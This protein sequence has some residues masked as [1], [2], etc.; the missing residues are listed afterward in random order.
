MT[1]RLADIYRREGEGGHIARIALERPPGNLIDREVAA[2]LRQ[3]P[4]E[5]D[6]EPAEVR[7]VLL[8]GLPTGP[9][10]AGTD[11][12]LLEE[13][14]RLSATALAD[15][16]DGY[17]VASS[18]AAIQR[19]VVAAIEGAAYEQGLELALAADVRVAGEGATFRLDHVGQG[20]IPWD[21]GTQRLSRVAGP[22]RA[23]EVLLT[24]RTVQAAEALEMGLVNRLV[25][26]GHALEAARELAHAIARGGPIAARYAKEA[27]HAGLDLSLE[28]GIILE[29]DLTMVLQ[30][31]ADR[32]EGIRSFLERRT[33]TF[34]GV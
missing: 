12:V 34:R 17:R 8:S 25:P 33:P 14:R 20:L 4:E 32:M 5:I 10:C 23:L 30:T 9:F 15:L 3:I 28:Q 24:G 7:V 29:T 19:P 6:R 26:H 21:G 16:L 11:P 2:L 31:T 18:I 13:A 27:V 22:S 1:L